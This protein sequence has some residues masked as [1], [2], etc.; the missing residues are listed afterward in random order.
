[1]M[2]A[3]AAEQELAKA[4]AM[5][6]EVK[7]EL[8]QLQARLTESEKT[9]GDR[10]LTA[11]KTGDQKAIGKINDEIAKLRNQWYVTSQTLGAARDA[12]I[13]AKHEINMARGYVLRMQAA[14][15][16]KQANE[17]QQKTNELLNALFEHEGV[18]YQ[19]EPQT[20]AGAYLAGSFAETRTAKL[21]QEA[22]A[23]IQRA[24][25]LER[26]VCHVEPAP[27]TGGRSTST[28][29]VG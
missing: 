16:M 13:G 9:A 11:R 10:C 1:M 3:E 21:A 2:T 20:S 25:S 29:L 8:D 18:H 28:V 15:L 17:R 5:E 26:Q 4:I 12:I 6:Q 14:E 22:A 23:L 7:G 27:S 19:P 24:D